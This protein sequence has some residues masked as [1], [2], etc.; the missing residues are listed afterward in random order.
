[1]KIDENKSMPR[2]SSLSISFPILLFFLFGFVFFFCLVK[3]GKIRHGVFFLEKKNLAYSPVECNPFPQ[4]RK[5]LSKSLSRTPH[6][7]FFFSIFF[8][9]GSK[10]DASCFFSFEESNDRD[11]VHGG[12][13]SAV[14]NRASGIHVR[15]GYGEEIDGGRK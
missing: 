1:M 13:S 11:P 9:S 7:F 3:L 8:F 2:G 6:V 12:A 10:N 4:W 5:G 15:L 14:S